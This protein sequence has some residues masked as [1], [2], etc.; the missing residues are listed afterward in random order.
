MLKK[1]RQIFRFI[2]SVSLLL[3]TISCECGYNACHKTDPKK[4]NIHLI[5]HSHDDVGW[6]VP[7]DEYYNSVRVI[8][9]NV[10]KSLELSSQRKFTQVEIYF[11]HRWWREQS[12]QTQD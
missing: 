12:Q 6:M 10:V 11:F 5:A 1:M 2:A 8:I 4:L 3:T 7:A 9:T